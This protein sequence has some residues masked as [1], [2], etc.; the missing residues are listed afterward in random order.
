MSL[1]KHFMIGECPFKDKCNFAHGE[2]ELRKYSTKPPQSKRRQ[3]VGLACAA[4]DLLSTSAMKPSKLNCRQQR[5]VRRNEITQVDKTQQPS[6]ETT[7]SPIGSS[8]QPLPLPSKETT[9]VDKMKQQS[10]LVSK[11]ITKRPNGTWQVQIWLLGKSRYIGVF[12]CVELAQDAYDLA[13]EFCSFKYEFPFMSE[14]LFPDELKTKMCEIKLHVQ[15]KIRVQ[16]SDALVDNS[17]IRL[18]RSN[19]L[20]CGSADTIDNSEIACNAVMCRPA[21][22][23]ILLIILRYACNAVMCRP[24]AQR[25]LLIIMSNNAPY[26]QG[27]Y[28]NVCSRRGN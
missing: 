8:P 23:Q 24:V 11:G 1:C 15:N 5:I 17:E 18:R 10:P 20:A 25:I 16:H 14:C 19:V 22:Q 21:A 13:V 7:H 4:S 28:P 6:N 27:C 12:K 3:S 26:V 9:Q 2:E